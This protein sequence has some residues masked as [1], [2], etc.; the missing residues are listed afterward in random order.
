META[1]S[2]RYQPLQATGRPR[3]PAGSLPRPA[4]I[5][6]LN[7]GAERRLTLI[8]APAGSGKTTLLA[9]WLEMWDR[10]CAWLSVDKDRAD[11]VPYVFDLLA[12]L[13]A[14]HPNLGRTSLRILRG[15]RKPVPSRL[16]E[17]LSQELDALPEP[18]G[19]VLDDFE[20]MRDP[21][22]LEFTSAFIQRCSPALHLVIA[23]RTDPP[24]PLSRLRAAGQLSEL[25][26]AD[27]YFSPAESA[28]FL[29][30]VSPRPISPQDVEAIVGRSEGWPA[31]LRLAALSLSGAS[32]TDPDTLPT[33]RSRLVMDYF[34][35]E[36]LAQTGPQVVVTLL[37]SSILEELSIPSV[38]AVASIPTATAARFLE[39]LERNNLFI[40]ALDGRAGWFRLHHLLRDTLRK[41]LEMMETPEAI[42]TLHRRAADWFAASGEIDLAIR[43]ALSAG[44]LDQACDLAESALLHALGSE[45]LL[46]QEQW[47][48]LL[49]EEAI[50]RRPLLLAIQ[51]RLVGGRTGW[52]VALPM[53]DAAQAMVEQEGAARWNEQP[54]IARGL[55]D[56]FRAPLFFFGGDAARSLECAERAYQALRGRFGYGEGWGGFFAGVSHYLLGQPQQGLRTLEAILRDGHTRGESFQVFFALLGLS[57]TH[58]LAARLPESE[59]AA[60]DM[61]AM[62]AAAG[63]E[64]GMAWSHYL[65]G[66]LTYETNRLPEAMQHFDQV[67]ALHQ[68]TSAL[69]LNDSMLGAALARQALGRAD[70]AAALLD[71]AEESILS[72]NGISFLANL[73]SLRA[74]IAL[75]Q[76]DLGSAQAWTQA[77]PMRM[78]TGP[79]IFLEV[80]PLTAARVLLATPGEQ[81]GREAMAM[82]SDIEARCQREHNLRYQI[83]VL[84]LQ[85]MALAKLGRQGPALEKM[86]SSVNL[87]RR[88][89]FVRT[90]VDLGPPVA[91]LLHSLASRTTHPAYVNRVLTAFA[92]TGKMG[93]DEPLSNR[94]EPLTPR[95]LQILPLLQRRFSNA[96]IARELGISVLTVKRHTGSLYAKL[97]VSGRKDAVRRAGAL[98]LLNPAD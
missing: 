61:L 70:Q 84:A 56:T 94:M 28:V 75:M 13:R 91:S 47:M 45:D 78:S 29:Q 10:R 85:A 24:L 67:I 20:H 8:S 14:L 55:I 1:E 87:A 23:S 63:R 82:L 4:L 54:V 18:T 58:L 51:A 89:G 97:Q 46:Q 96:E 79:L 88:G 11:L 22:A 3:P 42:A 62:E 25:R 83:S 19:L 43:H 37:R 40:V 60:Q 6:R 17:A 68:E 9:Q 21:A 32:S 71:E 12:A 50:R 76:G 92:G 2:T 80:P 98:G 49:P 95:E 16:A 57:I 93:G 52:R 64:F 48:S 34:L 27:L 86:E 7:Q 73:H 74:R 59:R 41:R 90:F 31:G 72:T 33:G 81:N 44:E 35:E 15:T 77:T 5:A 30:T 66:V 65:L 53:L 69:A 26:A 39:Y 38:A 36:V